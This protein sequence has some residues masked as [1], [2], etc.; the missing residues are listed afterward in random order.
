MNNLFISGMVSGKTTFREEA[1]DTPHMIFT[2]GVRAGKGYDYFRVSAWNRSAL[3]AKEHIT[4][5]TLV[6]V[7]GRLHQHRYALRNGHAALC[8]DMMEE[9]RPVIAD[10]LV[11]SLVNGHEFSPRD[12]EPPDSKGGVY[13]KKDAGKHFIAAYENKVRT[14]AKYLAYADFPVSFRRAIELQAGQY[15]KAVE[16]A[17][18]ALYQ[19]VVIR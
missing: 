7:H 12:F 17:N 10:S 11:L 15:A 14:Q 1:D 19:S 5:G 16:G 3:W 13:L 2:I 4:G 6:A 18:P 9:W 8:S